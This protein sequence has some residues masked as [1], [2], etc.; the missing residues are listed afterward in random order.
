MK[1]PN[2]VI[3]IPAFD[4]AASIAEVVRRARAAGFADVVVVD[5]GS[6]DATAS[7]ARGAGARVV[8]H[9]VNRGAGA[10]TRTGLDA[11]MAMGA[12]A[13]VTLDGDGQHDPAEIAAVLAP[14]LAGRADIAVGARLLNRRRMPLMVRGFNQVANA[15][16]WL[17]C[18]RWYRDSQSG[19]RAWSPRAM[20]RIGIESN[21]YEF[22]TEISREAAQERLAV[23]EV[24]VSACYDARTIGKGQ[25]YATGLETVFKLLV[26]SLMR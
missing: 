20:Q 14:V 12:A 16:A 11:A 10:A 21:G 23:V 9:L 2:V 19:F 26:R 7:L 3:V 15:V 8:S 17:L 22:C 5:D 13:A 24:P 25:G 18:G 1:S 6:A 4:E